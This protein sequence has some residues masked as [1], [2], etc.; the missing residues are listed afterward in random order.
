M[1]ETREVTVE[2][3]QKH[4]EIIRQEEAQ[5]HRMDK[6]A[7]SMLQGG[8]DPKSL[9]ATLLEGILAILEFER[10][11]LLI[12]EEKAGHPR[13][14]LEPADF[15]PLS[16]RVRKGSPG[17]AISGPATGI[18]ATSSGEWT[19]VLNPEFAVSRPLVKMAVASGQPLTIND[20]LIQPA[21]RSEQQHRAVLCQAF[22][23]LPG[24]KGIVYLDRALGG[25]ELG[26]R[27]ARTL[28][29]FCR[30]CLP[31]FDRAYAIRQLEVL[32]DRLDSSAA[33]RSNVEEA[34]AAQDEEEAAPEPGEV[35]AFHGIVGTDPK[36]EKIFHD[37]R[38]IRDSNL[39][40]CIFGESGTGKE[41]FA[42]A[43]HEESARREKPFVAQDCG[44]ISE[45]LLESELFGHAKGAFT[46]AHEDKKGLF[47]L[48][49]GGTLFLDEIGNM[50]KKM[51]Q[52]L[53]RVL[54]EHEIRPA[55]SARTIKVDVRV[56]CASNS[57]LRGLVQKGVFREDLFY[58]LRVLVF[59]I[60]PLRDRPGDIALLVSYFAD[61]VSKE[62]GIKKRFGQGAM[63]AL[64]QYSWPGN[65]RELQNVVKHVL[66]TCPRRVIARKD[67]G[68]Q[69]PESLSLRSGENMVRDEESLL[70][71][72]T[73]RDSFNEIIEECE[74]VVI[75]NAL[76]QCG[77]NKS[78][79]TK[80]L[81]IPR[82]SLYNKM[83]KYRLGKR[84][85]EDDPAAGAEQEEQE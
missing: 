44:A 5:R 78:K 26:D 48:A 37:I 71:R 41:L 30:Q 69:G 10:G 46:D 75:A 74:R 7:G 31:I 58:R 52:K 35:P 29:A 64:A 68:L 25:G 66:L 59:E 32:Q 56:I 28:A 17:Q 77:G 49:S 53:L 65:I 50:P 14:D 4:L 21:S 23:V 8:Y 42:K 70:I 85:D 79:V 34:A 40:I 43:I 54:E 12:S 22:E 27:E 63:K 62:E 82:Q 60:P 57:D 51:Q 13:S 24:L 61:Q 81:K 72:V 67:L 47:E 15:Q 19:D 38:K 83:A 55:G 18:L 33:G 73:P 36:L 76:K 80:A 16:S 84:G 39:S 2:S 6:I 20:C 1:D 9:G 11:F 3:L 45:S